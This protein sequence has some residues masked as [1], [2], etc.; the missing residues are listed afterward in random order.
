MD[1]GKYPSMDTTYEWG[2]KAPEQLSS[3]A[4]SLDIKAIAVFTSASLLI[5]VLST[6]AHGLKWGYPLILFGLAL[7]AFAIAAFLSF[8]ALHMRRM[9]VADDPKYIRANY[10]KMEPNEAK[11]KNWKRVEEAFMQNLEVVNSKSKALTYA[12]PA[13]AL[14]VVCLLAWLITISYEACP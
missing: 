3:E 7:V 6:V 9:N 1:E 12:L 4:S 11:M 14:E 8:S 13:L 10:W 5:G 2:R